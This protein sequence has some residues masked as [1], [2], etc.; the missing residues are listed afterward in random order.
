LLCCCDTVENS[1][2]GNTTLFV[3]KTTALVFCCVGEWLLGLLSLPCWFHTID[4]ALGGVVC[5]ISRLLEWS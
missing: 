1:L 3:G 2:L 5:V 4:E